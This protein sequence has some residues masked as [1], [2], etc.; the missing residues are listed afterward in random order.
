[1]SCD[2]VVSVPCPRVTLTDSDRCLSADL[3]GDQLDLS[4]PDQAVLSRL[5]RLLRAAVGPGLADP[6]RRLL[7]GSQ[8]VQGKYRRVTD[9]YRSARCNDSPA[10]FCAA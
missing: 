2:R 8:L 5:V 10:A 1:M 4:D 9:Q 3:A 6:V 7:A